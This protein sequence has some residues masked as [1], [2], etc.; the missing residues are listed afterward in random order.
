M[1][2]LNREPK[3]SKEQQGAVAA[4]RSLFA[5]P[6]Q[7]RHFGW[8]GED[9]Y[10][11]YDQ[12]SGDG[13]GFLIAQDGKTKRLDPLPEPLRDRVRVSAHGH[14]GDSGGGSRRPHPDPR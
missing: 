1:F 5:E 3:R 8:L 7:L 6:G 4:L 13:I 9:C 12:M 14:P 10:V 11:I 2:L